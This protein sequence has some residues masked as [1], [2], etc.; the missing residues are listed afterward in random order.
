MKVRVA[1]RGEVK[2]QDLID[3]VR[4]SEGFEECGAIVAFNGVVRG[5]GRDGSRVRK[6]V[7]EAYEEAVVEALEEVRREVLERTGAKELLIAHVVDEL[8]QGDDIVFIV[9]AAPHRAEAFKAAMEAI[10]LIKSR[11]PIWKKEVTELG[12]R[13]VSG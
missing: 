9:A 8:G 12:E 6:L 1:R 7:Y 2:L 10:E 13:W 5:V 11:A 3:E 4:R